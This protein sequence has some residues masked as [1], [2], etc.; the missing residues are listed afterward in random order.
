MAQQ[1]FSNLVCAQPVRTVRDDLGMEDP[2][3]ESMDTVREFADLPFFR[4]V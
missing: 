1:R 4:S 3:G 2:I